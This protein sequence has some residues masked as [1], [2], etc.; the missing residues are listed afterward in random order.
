MVHAVFMRPGA[1]VFE[2]GNFRGSKGWLQQS[3]VSSFFEIEYT[4]VYNT[5]YNLKGNESVWTL[6]DDIVHAFTNSTSRRVLPF[7]NKPHGKRAGKRHHELI[8]KLTNA[9]DLIAA[10]QF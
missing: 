6:T 7:R 3:N 10:A 4:Y 1:Q 9:T 8:S 5:W 2:L